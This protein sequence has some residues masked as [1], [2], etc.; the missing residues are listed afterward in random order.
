MPII[1]LRLSKYHFT[2][3][4]NQ[5]SWTAISRREC[6]N[7]GVLLEPVNVALGVTGGSV[8]L[9]VT[10]FGSSGV[11]ISVVELLPNSICGIGETRLS[12]YGKTS[13]NLNWFFVDYDVLFN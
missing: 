1:E 13:H 8:K 10:E 12:L 6:L 9:G 4:Y 7:I 5:N 2:G 11:I 3:V